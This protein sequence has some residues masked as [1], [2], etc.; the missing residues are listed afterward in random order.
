MNDL[1][2]QT[3]LA[4]AT[5]CSMNMNSLA[6][7]YTQNMEKKLECQKRIMKCVN[8]KYNITDHKSTLPCF[9]LEAKP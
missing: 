1:V 2:N 9:Y 8:E 7:Y 4:V 3:V 5:F 6:G